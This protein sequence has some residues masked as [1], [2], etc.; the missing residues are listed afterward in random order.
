M[1]TFEETTSLAE[2]MTIAVDDMEALMNNSNYLFNA[3]YWH[4]PDV[5][6]ENMCR[7]CMA[8]AVIANSLKCLVSS[9]KFPSHFKADTFCKLHAIESARTGDIEAAYYN[10]GKFEV[11]VKDFDVTQ[12]D[13]I[14][15]AAA[16]DFMR[17][18]REEGIPELKRIETCL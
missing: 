16:W 14:G 13:F 5:Y 3:H 18:W 11:K 7:I 8:G 10:L 6:A 17:F 15:R 2:L 9:L 1:K 4:Q 12:S